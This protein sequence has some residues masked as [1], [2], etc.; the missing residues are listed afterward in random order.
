MNR[1]S[2]I[3]DT[4]L[5]CGSLLASCSAMP[6]IRNGAKLPD[7]GLC[8]H[9]GAMET[10]PEN[11]IPAYQAA[12]EAGAHMIEFDVWLTRDNG[13]AVLHDATVDRTTDGTGAIAD[14]TLSDVRSLD[15]G[16]WKAPRFA[17]LRIPT[18]DEALEVMP[19]NVWLNVHLKGSPEL[20]AAAARVIKR[21]KRLHQAFLACGHEMAEAARKVV[22]EILICN[23][24]RQSNKWD[25]VDQTIVMNAD[26]IQLRK[27]INDQFSAYCKK[28]SDNGVRIN[29]FGTDDPEELRRLFLAGI[30]FP[31]ANDIINTMPLVK[32]FGITPNTPR[33]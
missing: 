15:A 18:M 28:L 16:S 20:G 12:A 17:G 29:Y 14:L 4:V 24:D 13:L 7:R 27:P 10:H 11:T 23:M 8:A 6:G 33:Y 9:R 31:L 19:R 5:T 26:F 30:Q 21:H 32:E 25:Y 22:P 2:F 3:V 1:R